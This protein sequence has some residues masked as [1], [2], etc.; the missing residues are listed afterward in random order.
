M[1][2]TEILRI[3]RP[4][5][6]LAR[7]ILPAGLRR[8]LYDGLM[9]FEFRRGW[10]IWPTKDFEF[11]VLLELLLLKARPHSIVEFG[12]GRSTFVLA[13]YAHKQRATL[14]S[15]EDNPHFVRKVRAGL[16][17]ALL[18][19][20]Y[21]H[22]AKISHDRW[23]DVR[24]VRRAIPKPP[25]M[26]LIDGPYAA[27]SGGLR[28]SPVA[29][30]FYRECMATVRLLIVDDVDRKAEYDMAMELVA[31]SSLTERYFIK[32]TGGA[33]ACIAVPPDLAPDCQQ[34][35]QFLNLPQVTGHLGSTVSGARVWG[36][37]GARS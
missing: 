20:G 30:T 16:D 13:G 27:V 34:I 9:R 25:D 4:A 24:A 23:Y 10:K 6:K 1:T 15:I 21:V 5:R 32:D 31:S 33:I 37:G 29:L 28:Y 2:E 22:L 7:A 36:T 3:P 11:W 26:L 35:L 14:A 12:S 18:P 8:R 19:S 17:G